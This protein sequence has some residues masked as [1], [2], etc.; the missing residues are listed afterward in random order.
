MASGH[1]LSRLREVEHGLGLLAAEVEEQLETKPINLL[2]WQREVRDV[3]RELEEGPWR[4]E[5]A[6]SGLEGEGR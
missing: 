6:P 1:P 2:Y 4:L 5:P 3:I